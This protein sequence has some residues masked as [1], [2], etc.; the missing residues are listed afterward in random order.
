LRGDESYTEKWEY[1]KANPV[2]AGLVREP[3]DWPYQGVLNTLRS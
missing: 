2:R 3:E 1:V